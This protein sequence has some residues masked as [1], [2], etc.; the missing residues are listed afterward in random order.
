[1]RWRRASAVIDRRLEAARSRSP[2]ISLR[3]CCDDRPPRRLCRLHAVPLLPRATVRRS[4]GAPRPAPAAR[5]RRH[6]RGGRERD[7]SQRRHG[8]RPA[9][10]HRDGRRAHRARSRCRCSGRL[11]ADQARYAEVAPPTAGQVVRVLVELNAQV[12]PGTPLAQLRST[13]LGRARA[14]LL[15]AEA[16]R[17]LARQTLERKRTLAAERIV[18]HARSAGGRGGVPRGRRRGACGRGRRCGRSASSTATTP[19]A[20]SSLFYAP[21]ADRRP[22]HRSHAPCSASTPSRR[23]AVHDRRSVARL[24]HGAGLRARR[25]ERRSRARIGARHGGGAAGPGVRRPRDAGRPAGRCRLADRARSHRAGECRRRAAPGHVGERPPRGGGP[26]P[27]RFSP[28]R[29]RRCSASASGGW[30]SC[31]G[32]S[33]SSRCGRS[34]AAAISATTSR[35]CRG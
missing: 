14:D 26:E 19:A 7:S 24:A 29:P 35:W 34:A 23:A 15:S 28:C 27:A 2:S 30:R 1:M 18:A 33:T 8:A 21:V 4:R 5:R 17:D 13:E 12:R 32:R 25:G 22:G 31:R 3:E 20:D 9:H 6:A 10:Q 11:A 16:R